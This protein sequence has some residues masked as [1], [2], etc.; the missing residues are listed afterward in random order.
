[1]ETP[2]L[3]L[4]LFTYLV[5]ETLCYF[6]KSSEKVFT[7]I[8]ATAMIFHFLALIVRSVAVQHPPFTNLYETFLLLPFLLV[9]RLVFWRRQFPKNIRWLILVIICLLLLSAL[10]MPTSYK[11]PKPLMPAL[12]SFWMYIHVPSYFFGY[13]ALILGFINAVALL[14]RRRRNPEQNGLSLVNRMD[15]EIKIAFLFLNIGMITGGIWAYISW[16]NYWSWDPKETWALVNIFI[17]AYYFHLDKSTG[18][19]K[20]VIVIL[21][22]LSVIFTYLGVTFILSGLH[23]YA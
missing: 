21:T 1:M 11:M 12:N 13:M 10:V 20:A 14:A 23:S 8:T 18:T 4:S 9:L 7:Y 3:V 16:G 17:L 19:K 2:L 5:A 22:L 6:K 15:T